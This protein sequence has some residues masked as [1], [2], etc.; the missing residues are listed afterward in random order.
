MNSE[1]RE[2]NVK[3]FTYFHFLLFQR[4]L[5]R[6]FFSTYRMIMIQSALGCPDPGDDFR[7]Q[8]CLSKYSRKFSSDSWSHWVTRKFTISQN[9]LWLLELHFI[10]ISLGEVFAATRKV[11]R[12][13]RRTCFVPRVISWIRETKHTLNQDHTIR[14]KKNGAAKTS[15][16]EILMK[17]SSR[18]H[19][20][21][22]LI[23]SFQVTQWLQEPLKIF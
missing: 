11:S 16:S 8:T 1:Y 12:V 4:F 3:S 7:Y 2:G 15:P 5:P 22:W 6:H 13:L 21:F 10:K 17:W 9:I 23:V 20:I 18:S 14:R 19:R